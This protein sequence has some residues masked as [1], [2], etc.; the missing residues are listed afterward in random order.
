M[1]NSDPGQYPMGIGIMSSHHVRVASNH[2]HD[3]G[4]GGIG[5]VWSNHVRVEANW[6]H[7]T[8]RWAPN[9]TSAISFFQSSNDGGGNNP[10]GFSNYAVGNVVWNNYMEVP[11]PDGQFTDGHCVLVDSGRD[12]NSQGGTYI[13]N[14]ICVRNGGSGVGVY[15]SDN[16][17]AVNNTLVENDRKSTDSAAEMRAQLANNVV[18]RNNIVRPTAGMAVNGVYQATA[19]SFD[20]NLYVAPAAAYVGAGDI[21]DANARMGFGI[22]PDGGGPAINS[23][24]AAS[25]PAADLMGTGRKGAP[26]RG[27]LELG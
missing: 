5:M 10:D 15:R 2:V 9:A 19:V 13:A 24:N 16:V 25:A 8:S 17:L 6:V 1:A 26:D 7:G 12:T 21:V 14:N 4:G 11:G 23:G 20:H 22:V 27:A 18:F 3:V